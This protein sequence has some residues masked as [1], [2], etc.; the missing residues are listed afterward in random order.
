[1]KSA[2]IY[3][4]FLKYPTSILIFINQVTIHMWR[5]EHKVNISCYASCVR[6]LPMNRHFVHEHFCSLCPQCLKEKENNFFRCNITLVLFPL[7]FW[8]WRFTSSQ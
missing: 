7:C 5:L 8:V 2:N 4:R 6:C 3:R 1:M